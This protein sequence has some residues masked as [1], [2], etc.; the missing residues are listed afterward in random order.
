MVF[1]SAAELHCKFH[2][3][4]LKR[5]RSD[6]DSPDWMYSKKS[7]INSKN[8]DD[9]CFQYAIAVTLN[10]AKIKKDHLRIIKY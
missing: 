8:N 4:S 1:D 2:M 7:T 5:G 9:N 3:T 6:I 10:Y